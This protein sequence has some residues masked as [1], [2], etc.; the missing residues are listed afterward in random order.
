MA[1]LNEGMESYDKGD[2]ETAATE[3]QKLKVK[4]GFVLYTLGVMFE[5]GQWDMGV[6]S[7]L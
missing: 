1:G 4:N 2:F 5:N 3:F 6:R 7:S